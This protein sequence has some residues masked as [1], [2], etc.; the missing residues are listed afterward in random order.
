MANWQTYY[1]QDYSG[2]LHDTASPLEI[3]VNEASKLRNWD[4]TYQGQLVRRDGL[5]LLGNKISNNPILSGAAFIR[6]LGVDLLITESTN[7]WFLNGSSFSQLA[8]NLVAEPVWFENVEVYEK[9]FL[10]SE[11]N[12]LSFWDRVSTT[13]DMALTDIAASTLTTVP[14]GN[15]V[16][17]YKNH[18]FTLNNVNVGGVKYA[19][20]LYWANIGDPTL[21]T[22]WDVI[23]NTFQ[24]PGDG[25]LIT[26]VPL[27]DQLILFK[28]RA[29]QYLTG[30]G[31]NSWQ[32][33]ESSSDVSSLDERIGCP[34]VRGAVRVG[35][36]VWFVDQEANIRRIYQTDF[37]ALRRDIISTKI[38]G[39]LSGINKS[40]LSK[41]VAWS[42]NQK[43]YFAFPNGTDTS[44]SILCVFDL[45]ASKR[46]T[47]NPYAP[48]Y[49]E[50]WTTITGWFPSVIFDYPTST[51][52]D[53]IIGD[54]TTGQ[55]YK[56]SGLDDNG[57]AIDARWDGK[58]DFYG[59]ENAFK[60]FGF[61]YIRGQSSGGLVPVDIWGSLD[62]SAGA[63]LGVLNLQTGGS[64]LGP[65]GQFLLGPTGK[66]QLGGAA[67][68][69][70]KFFFSS[71]GAHAYN[72]ATVPSVGG[73]S[74]VGK[75]VLM[76]I[77]HNIA[78]QKPTVNGYS[79]HFRDRTLR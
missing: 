76:S 46:T 17:W 60:T 57:V 53:L 10:S 33:T 63:K 14:H 40:Q 41:C 11:N 18:L 37:N 5:T 1:Q 65:T 12:P 78:G 64:K 25:R 59:E 44:N 72:G 52:P 26:A 51:T 61:G 7:L 73:S 67:Q 22:S 66:N 62:S 6:T 3:A 28:E 77:R 70:Q 36:E 30:W 29:I 19:N 8:D 56:K 15:V 79:V 38:Q 4:I 2:G 20:S 9:I 24:A 55:V 49:E 21:A 58:Q 71:G 69:E 43:V 54:A 27:G 50:A 74:C 32:I 23:N 48:L 39:T 75:S 42:N 68:N 34:A 45:I 35:N 13:V 47:Q 16:V 31:N